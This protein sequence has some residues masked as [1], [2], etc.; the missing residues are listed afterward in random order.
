MATNDRGKLDYDAP[1]AQYWP[2]FGAAGK[3]AITVR[4]LLGHQA[5]LL[6]LDEPQAGEMFDFELIS[7][8]FAAQA[9]NWPP[10]E[11]PA[12]NSLGFGFLVGTLVQ[13]IDGRSIQQF[14][15]EELTDP[16]GADYILGAS[17]EDLLRVAPNIPNPKNTLMSGGILASEKVAKIFA[18]GPVDPALMHSP[19]YL[20]HVFPS[21]NG[22]AHADALARIFAP[23]ANG[24]KFLGRQVFSP[25]TVTAMSE[26]QWHAIDSVFGNEFRVALGLLQNIDFNFFGREGNVGSAGGGGYTV[27]AD[28][29]NHLTFAYTPGRMTSG[30]GLGIESRNLV[31]ALYSIF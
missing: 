11:K 22:I 3:E 4:Q 31:R 18:S 16:I 21:G 14:I 7:S 23:L 27:F 24:G 19:Q 8:R 9:P 17:D 1:V 29:E 26:V 20:K 13:R 2:E 15:R 12:Y 28:P 30:D 25:E 10:T 6:Y 5:S